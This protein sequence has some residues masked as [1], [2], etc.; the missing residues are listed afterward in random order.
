ML[1]TPKA[2]SDE[3]FFTSWIE[4]HASLALALGKPLI[5]EEMGKGVLVNSTR[6]ALASSVLSRRQ[7]FMEMVYGQ[8]NQSIQTGG[9]WRGE[10]SS[11][12]LGAIF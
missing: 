5:L 3:P 10:Q 7:P 9:S 11:Y 4:R 6:D 8:F 2:S 1:Q 12:S